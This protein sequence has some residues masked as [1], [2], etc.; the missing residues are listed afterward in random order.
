MGKPATQ[1][2]KHT[3]INLANLRNI[4]QTIMNEFLTSFTV[5]KLVKIKKSVGTMNFRMACGKIRAAY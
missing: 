2:I 5:K 1:T 3:T 4:I